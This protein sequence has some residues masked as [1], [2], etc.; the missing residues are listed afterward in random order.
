MNLDQAVKG[1]YFYLIIYMAI[2]KC[3]NFRWNFSVGLH[4][5]KLPQISCIDINNFIDFDLNAII[6]KGILIASLNNEEI[7]K[8]QFKSPIVT[9]WKWNGEELKPVNLFAQKSSLISTDIAALYLGMHNKQLYIHESELLLNNMPSKDPRT[10]LASIPWKPVS[11]KGIAA[12]TTVNNQET[13]TSVLQSTE[14]VN[15]GYLM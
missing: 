14:Y 8:Y 15:G 12:I 9:V 10:S 5:I 11:A 1:I 2:A 4:N 13:G 6:P 3:F 7:W